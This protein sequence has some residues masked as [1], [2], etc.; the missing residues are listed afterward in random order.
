[1]Q[2]MIKK[3]NRN[4][5]SF[6]DRIS[7]KHVLDCVATLVPTR[8]S[9]MKFLCCIV[10]AAVAAATANLLSRIVVEASSFNSQRSSGQQHDQQKRL[11]GRSSPSF[12]TRGG[13]KDRSKVVYFEDDDADDDDKDMSSSPTSST[14]QV[15]NFVVGVDD[16]E[17]QDILLDDINDDEVE[18]IL[19]ALEK[20]EKPIIKR[21]KRIS[22]GKKKGQKKHAGKKMNDEQI[23]KGRHAK[24]VEIKAAT[25]SALET[26]SN[27]T[28]QRSQVSIQDQSSS[29][30]EKVMQEH[31]PTKKDDS[32]SF[33]LHP[34]TRPSTPTS[35][36]QFTAAKSVSISTEI[37]FN[38]IASP[39]EMTSTTTVQV[40]HTLTKSITNLSSATGKVTQTIPQ[41]GQST[42]T[43][44]G[45]LSP[46]TPSPS[47]MLLPQSTRKTRTPMPSTS[48][49]QTTKAAKVES[50]TTPWV[51]AFLKQRPLDMLLPIP[52]DYL[53]DNFNLSQL[54]PIV[55][56][57]GFQVMGEAAIPVAKALQQH[58]LQVALAA[59]AQGTTSTTKTITATS[60][61]IYRLALRMIMKDHDAVSAETDD[62]LKR[63]EEIIPSHAVQKAAEALY[64]LVHARFV[65]SPRGL[66]AIRHV[67]MLDK[68]VFGKCPRPLCR[69]CG[70][71]PYGYS[72]DYNSCTRDRLGSASDMGSSINSNLCHRYCPSCG[73][74]WI[75]WNSKTDGCAWGPSWCHLF[76]LSFGTQVFS[77]ELQYIANNLN[78]VATADTIS[79][80]R[81]GEY[82][83][84][85]PT[86]RRPTIAMASSPTPSVFGFRIH[87]AT[88]FGTPFNEQIRGNNI[89]RSR[90]VYEN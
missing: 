90:P 37:P 44:K 79:R 60:Y 29:V 17:F 46:S 40:S 42:V 62:C 76:L 25:S 8:L 72:A 63:E 69:G 41:F 32:P 49:K 35:P 75:S 53:G 22:S 80:S 45:V 15:S 67:M 54:P 86:S 23:I 39:L 21:K 51:R 9:N 70:T 74:V 87:P 3:C 66:E 78:N 68:T 81:T 50:T 52:K 14:R 38:H 58:R 1:M 57:I 30:E 55:E 88:P 13:S 85:I 24:S 43:S 65:I 18:R 61:P 4:R 12:P 77:E 59:T 2:N 84:S 20:S 71:L 7:E 89:G 10:V 27:T 73:E 56:R 82:T 34:R 6:Y 19:L 11:S 5:I 48:P 36:T 16:D 26:S 83:A 33:S 64:L 47:K 28:I 31:Q